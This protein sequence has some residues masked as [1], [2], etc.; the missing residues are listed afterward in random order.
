VFGDAIELA[1]KK[2]ISLNEVLPH[3]GRDNAGR[4][5]RLARWLDPLALLPDQKKKQ[6][7]HQQ[8]QHQKQRA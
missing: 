1:N 6:Q 8:Q 2:Q 3:F 7:Q 4:R 5:E